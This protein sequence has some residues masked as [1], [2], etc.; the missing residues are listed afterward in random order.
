MMNKEQR[1][2][3]QNIKDRLQNISEELEALGDEEQE[4]FDNLNEGMQAME[5]F[6]KLEENAEGFYCAQESIEECIN[7]LDEFEE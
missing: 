2:K 4:K 5:K 7:T 6:Q 3:L 1:E